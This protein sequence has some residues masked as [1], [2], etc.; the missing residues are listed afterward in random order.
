[1]NSPEIGK[2]VEEID[3]IEKVSTTPIKIAFSSKYFLDALKTFNSSEVYVK[4]TGEI[5][6]FIIEGTD[7][8]GLI[9]LILPVRTE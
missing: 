5:R 2:V 7:D 3:P 8:Q 6:P 9:Q 4:F 1:S